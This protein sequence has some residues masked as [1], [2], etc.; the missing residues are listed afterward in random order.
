MSRPHNNSFNIVYVGNDD[1]VVV[2]IENSMRNNEKV[3]ISRY[4][5]G[6][7][8][9]TA[10]IVIVDCR[11]K[12]LAQ[13]RLR[14]RADFWDATFLALVAEASLD[15]R[16]IF[17]NDYQDYLL[18]PLIVVEV[19]RRLS[20]CISLFE[21]G[22]ES[23]AFSLDPFVQRAARAMT[24]QIAEQITL[25]D[26][27]RQLGSNRNRLAAAF[28]REFGCGPM[29]WLRQQ[30]MTAAANQLHH[31]ERPVIEVSISVGY[32]N[33]DNFSTAFK[34]HFGLSPQA[35]RKKVRNQR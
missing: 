1:G 6:E 28:K 14:L 23:R 22:R 10:D 19:Q 15:R 2:T 11:Q 24:A 8:T 3:S 31:S 26:L 9:T 35:Y 32:E 7:N 13:L 27:A 21:T 30:R 16:A 20:S 33:S 12:D 34:R 4:L 5:E 17:N 29:A 18:W 25:T